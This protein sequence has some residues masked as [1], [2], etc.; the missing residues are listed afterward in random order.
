SSATGIKSTQADLHNKAC[1]ASMITTPY[2]THPVYTINPPK[3]DDSHQGHHLGEV[4]FSTAP[5]THPIIQLDRLRTTISTTTLKRRSTWSSLEGSP[6]RTHSGA[7]CSGR[8][9]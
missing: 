3:P 8:Q 2:K 7:S 6:I 9:L 5:G 1:K 4:S